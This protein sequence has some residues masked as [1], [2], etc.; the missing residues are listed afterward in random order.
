MADLSEL[1]LTTYEDQAYR[2]LL[3]LGATT[4]TTLAAESGVPEGRI[5]DVLSNLEARG[6]VRSQEASRPKRYVAVEPEVAVDRLAEGQIRELEAQID[7]YETVAA[8][9]AEE[10][11]SETS[12]EDRFWT[13]AIG[14]DDAVEL[15]FERIDAAD[16]EVIMVADAVPE[17][18]DLG[19]VGSDLL[20]RLAKSIDRDV[21]VSLLVSE[22]ILTEIP[23]NLF[24]RAAS[25]PFDANRFTVRTTE[26]L[27]GSLY[28]IDNAELCIPVISPIERERVL[29]LINLK[30]PSFARELDKRFRMV[31]EDSTIVDPKPD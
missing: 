10:L 27:Y 8:E 29:G 17:P 30:D 20:D 4:A 18:L 23:R 15:L 5:Y 12:V 25:G 31:W 9:A 24:D 13:T 2:S 7:R 21:D 14:T 19:E 16:S 6:M 28:L 1:G 26:T 22:D 3:T 11:G